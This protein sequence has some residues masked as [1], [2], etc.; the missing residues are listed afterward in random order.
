MSSEADAD[1]NPTRVV[2]SVLGAIALLLAWRAGMVLNL[3]AVGLLVHVVVGVVRRS[4]AVVRRRLRV[5]WLRRP[6]AR[7]YRAQQ[8]RCLTNWT[9]LG[10]IALVVHVSI[11]PEQL[12]DAHASARW[13]SAACIIVAVLLE[14]VPIVPPRTGST[15][16]TGATSMFLG[17]QLLM[18][19]REPVDDV[20]VLEPPMAE[21]L[22]V[23]QGGQSPLIN[24]HYL[25]S[26]QRHALDLVTVIDGRLD[27]EGATGHHAAACFGK[28]VLAPA[29][30]HVVRVRDELPDMFEGQVDESHPVGNYVAIE[31]SPRRYVL[32]A[33]LRQG[34]VRVKPG[35]RVACGQPIAECGNS[36]NTSEAHLHMQVQDA[37]DF[38]DDVTTFPIKFRGVV[39]AGERA[40]E[41]IAPRRNDHLGPGAPCVR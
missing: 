23:M 7:E 18:I 24:H 38:S 3:F 9:F 27:V 17:V 5:D 39:R 20:V 35:D 4:V 37:A 34:S 22:L 14:L 13:F 41:P 26:S 16:I 28:A 2:L 1:A 33:H 19:L 29:A 10:M 11:V 25:V 36:G 21:Q 31:L 40:R 30:G 8:L 32:L 12:G 6:W 15:I